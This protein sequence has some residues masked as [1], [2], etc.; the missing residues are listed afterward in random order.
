VGKVIFIVA[1]RIGG[2]SNPEL[3]GKLMRNFIYSLARNEAARP[4]LVLFMNEG[5]KLVCEGSDSLD[6]LALLVDAGV[7]VK[8]CGTCLDYLGLKDA[9][10]VGEVGTMPDSVAALM[11]SSDVVTVC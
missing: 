2:G 11:D 9:V 3:G 1:D 5:V 10:R 6:D 4:S 7:G 8:A